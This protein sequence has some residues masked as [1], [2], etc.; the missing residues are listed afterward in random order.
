MSE[1]FASFTDATDW[2][3]LGMT[4]VCILCAGLAAGLTIGLVS[5]DRNELRLLLINGKPEEK[6]QATR[7]LPLIKD[8]HWYVE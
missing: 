3:N 7:V 4:V 6:A 8:H 2:V 5:I 1:E